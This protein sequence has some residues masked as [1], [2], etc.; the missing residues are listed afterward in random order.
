MKPN[1]SSNILVIDNSLFSSENDFG[2][3]R[4]N[5]AKDLAMQLI[6]KIDKRS[7]SSKFIIISSRDE[8]PDLVLSSNSVQELGAVINSIKPDSGKLPIFDILHLIFLM[9]QHN[10]VMECNIFFFGCSPVFA[11]SK[12]GVQDVCE[13]LRSSKFNLFV[14]SLC[15][16]IFALQ[17][18]CEMVGGVFQCPTEN[19]LLFEIPSSFDEY[20]IPCG[21]RK[22]VS[23]HESHLIGSEAETSKSEI[24][25]CCPRCSFS[26]GACPLECPLCGLLVVSSLDGMNFKFEQSIYLN[27]ARTQLQ[28]TCFACHETASH[29]SSCLRCHEC[30]CTNCA[31]IIRSHWHRLPCCGFD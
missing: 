16:E 14:Y 5:C 23:M 9:F 1:F 27:E 20:L 31:T 4:L 30:Y 11:E 13:N 2:S 22:I 17:H 3:T 7:I 25:S 26:L 18:I 12:N 15:G 21:V 6:E 29:C 28:A 24:I 19:S 8:R 10:R